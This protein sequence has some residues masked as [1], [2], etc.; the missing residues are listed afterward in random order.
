MNLQ[1]L[2]ET[3]RT[4]GIPASLVSLGRPAES[5]WCVVPSRGS[6]EV[7]W[8]AGTVR[9]SHVWLDSEDVACYYLLGRLVYDQVLAGRFDFPG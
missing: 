4:L 9:H 3:L 8:N 6:R 2:D 5:A 1:V 7:Y